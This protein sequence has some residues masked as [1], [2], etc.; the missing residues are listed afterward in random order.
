MSAGFVL[1]PA[2][3]H[4]IWRNKRKTGQ[5]FQ[6]FLLSWNADHLS[7]SSLNS[8]IFQISGKPCF[9]QKAS[10]TLENANTVVKTFHY[11]FDWSVLVSVMAIKP[12]LRDGL[13]TDPETTVN[14]E[15]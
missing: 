5:E 2:T 9:R 12:N 13:L 10:R 1:C 11:S 14:Y 6:F 8:G 7:I 3:R 4:A 15:I